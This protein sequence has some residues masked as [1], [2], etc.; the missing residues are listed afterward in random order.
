M[1]V[2]GGHFLSVGGRRPCWEERQCGKI[3]EAAVGALSHT[4]SMRQRHLSKEGNEKTVPC[5]SDGRG[6]RQGKDLEVGARLCSL[7]EERGVVEGHTEREEEH[8]HKPDPGDQ[9]VKAMA[10]FKLWCD[11]DFR[12]E[13]GSL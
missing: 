11:F 2:P 3:G 10:P 6:H 7:K 5:L 4:A 12:L 1:S 9:R 13:I 8:D